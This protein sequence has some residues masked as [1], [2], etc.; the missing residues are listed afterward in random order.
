MRVALCVLA[1]LACIGCESRPHRFPFGLDRMRDQP[2]YDPYER[3]TYFADGTTMRQPPGGTI[4]IE[5]PRTDGIDEARAEMDG[6]AAPSI[7]IPVTRDLLQRGRERY[8]VFCRPCHDVDGGAD[9]PV[10]RNMQLRPPPSLLE[11]RIR[12]LPVGRLYDAIADGYGLMPSYRRQLTAEERWAVVAYVR[13][14]QL[15]GPV[16]IDDLP[17]QVKAEAA[18]AL[19]SGGAP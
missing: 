7:P 3:S 16:A 8:D 17:P 5:A 4:P 13:A 14:L 18:R 2:R 10:A 9:S 15:R 1:A 12:Q 19:G 6:R 11:N